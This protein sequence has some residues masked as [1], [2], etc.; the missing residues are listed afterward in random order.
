MAPFNKIAGSRSPEMREDVVD[1]LARRRRSGLRRGLGPREQQAEGSA[2][3]T[4][5]ALRKTAAARSPGQAA[6][7]DAE[8]RVLS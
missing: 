1:I 4:V 8:K 5:R 2:P 7:V 6:D 3:L